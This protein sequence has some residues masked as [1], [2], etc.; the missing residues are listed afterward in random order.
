MYRTRVLN[1]QRFY[2]EMWWRR[3]QDRRYEAEGYVLEKR[4]R[5]LKDQTHTTGWYLYGGTY[6]GEWCASTLRAAV[7]EADELV[8]ADKYS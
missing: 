2:G 5:N 8:Y 1:G 6:F 3:T 7:A 4:R